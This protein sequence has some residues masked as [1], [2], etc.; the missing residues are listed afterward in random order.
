MAVRGH[1]FLYLFVGLLT[2]KEAHNNPTFTVV[3][4]ALALTTIYA[5]EPQPD[6][7]C[8]PISEYIYRHIF[9]ACQGWAGG[10]EEEERVTH[11]YLSDTR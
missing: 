1:I 9:G 11:G 8:L 6:T 5:A 3:H 7:A 2:N 10:R 4:S